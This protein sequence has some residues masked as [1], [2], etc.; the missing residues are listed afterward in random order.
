MTEW[1]GSAAACSIIGTTK[2]KLWRIAARNGWKRKTEKI[3]GRNCFLF[4]LS[5]VEGCTDK[6]Q[7]RETHVVVN[8]QEEE[9][10]AIVEWADGLTKWPSDKEIKARATLSNQYVD[11]VAMV[12][13]RVFRKKPA[14][15][16]PAMEIDHPRPRRR[17]D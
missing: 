17:R 8:G 3:N 6:P 9:V 14:L 1:I 5:D 11:I 15:R 2:T 7:V 12:D 4:R 16:L 10:R 13:T